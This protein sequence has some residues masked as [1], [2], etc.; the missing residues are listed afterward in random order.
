MENDLRSVF[1][2]NNTNAMKKDFSCLRKEEKEIKN[3]EEEDS[4]FL[5][6]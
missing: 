3:Q 1:L 4:Y 6:Q 2:T 5:K